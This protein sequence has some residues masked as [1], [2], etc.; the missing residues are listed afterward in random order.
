[1][2]YLLIV[3]LVVIAVSLILTFIGLHNAPLMPDDY[4][5]DLTDVFTTDKDEQETNE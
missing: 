5:E 4:G 3:L 2:S 1:M